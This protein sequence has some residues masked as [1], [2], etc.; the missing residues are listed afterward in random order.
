MDTDGWERNDGRNQ[1]DGSRG[2]VAR[3]A[4]ICQGNDVMAS[5][6]RLAMVLAAAGLGAALAGCA[7]RAQAAPG[8]A[9]RPVATG[10]SVSFHNAT[11]NAASWTW[12]FGDGV[13]STAR[14]PSHAYAAA[15]AYTV[16]LSAVST[17]GARASLSKVV[18][19]KP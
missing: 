9:E 15:G 3:V 19:V 13:T 6:A 2:T 12:D 8:G 1:R 11:K 7:Q 5:G 4:G 10:L 16:T 17:T 18:T 14:N